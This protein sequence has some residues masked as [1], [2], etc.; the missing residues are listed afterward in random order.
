MIFASG[1]GRAA[2]LSA[3]ATLLCLAGLFAQD[4]GPGPNPPEITT[5]E[6]EPA[7]RIESQRNLVVVRV[8]VRD[9]QGRAVN[10]LH[11]GDFRLL[12]NGKPQTLASFSLE[13]PG[14]APRATTPLLPPTVARN[15]AN[16]AA[17]SAP[18]VTP[19]ITQ[20][21]LALYFDDVHT[22]FEDMA[23]VRQA[24][25]RYLAAS[26]AGS[27]QAGIFTASGENTLDF[28][29]DRAEL[30]QALARLLPRPMA[31]TQVNA[32]P[33]ISEYQAYLIA[34]E[35]DPT[36]SQIASDEYFGCNCSNL[37]SNAW[38]QCRQRAQRE[39]EAEA[40]ET[41]KLAETGSEQSLRS[42]GR[43]VQRLGV[44]EGQRSIILVSPG[45]LEF[46]LTSHV[47]QIIDRALRANIV[48]GA[49]DAKG[50]YN[51]LPLGDASERALAP[52]LAV[53]GTDPAP[54]RSPGAASTATTNP[55][56]ATD[57]TPAALS[58]SATGLKTQIRADGFRRAA[59]VMSD[60]AASTGGFF[61]Q[62]SN[63]YDAGFRKAG[64]LPEAYYVLSFS[65][66]E[67]R[68][69]GKF[70]SLKVELS[71]ARGLSVEARRGY[72]APNGEL[73]AQAEARQELVDLVF[74]KEETAAIPIVL[75]TGFFKAGA[76]DA[77][78][79]VS[80]RI[81]LRSLHF[82]RA[83]GRNFDEVTFVTALFDQGGRYMTGKQKV[84]SLR[85]RD[86][87]LEKL[88]QSG[89]TTKAG[90]EV[91]PGTYLVREVVMDSEGRL[92]SGT[93]RTVEIP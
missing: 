76:G 5:R 67:L 69:D 63:D 42:L 56:I 46:T 22:S 92:L 19:I 9:A 39:V 88:A 20:R 86:A 61:F 1:S 16:P 53:R 2:R 78:L 72:Y 40:R 49:L 34:V 80:A 36:S 87:S 11:Q 7:F 43:L 35:N 64:G 82:R 59:D 79:R 26:L 60:L 13:T 75:N 74:S 71:N 18:A 65:P 27:D 70:H 66:L 51:E 45:F 90:F 33:E 28:T 3:L 44:L 25:D 52:G 57:S 14:A 50:L 91:R 31:A 15:Q 32:C 4:A 6:S 37:P 38:P 62:N 77:E 84:L 85:L 17:A 68:R 55:E 47:D 93:S 24:A 12:D 30:H 10:S 29:G 21:F 58:G 41:F 54:P 89:V 23:R 73:D 8:V 81:D 83:E 48:I